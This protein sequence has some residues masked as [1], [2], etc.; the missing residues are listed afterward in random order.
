MKGFIYLKGPV[1][2]KVKLNLFQ[3]LVLLFVAIYLIPMV[4]L[5]TLSYQISNRTLKRQMAENALRSVNNMTKNLDDFFED[6]GKI[7]DDIYHNELIN[8]I[9]SGK[10]PADYDF[11]EINRRVYSLFAGKKYKT[12]VYILDKNG[13]PIYNSFPL[14]KKYLYKKENK[15]WGIFREVLNAPGIKVYYPESYMD[16]QGNTISLSIAR[17]VFNKNNECMGFIFLDVYNSHIRD[18]L[19]G[20]N[21]M[22]AQDIIIIDK[23]NYILYNSRVPTDEGSFL[24]APYM[25]DIKHGQGYF[26]KQFDKKPFLIAYST[27]QLTGLTIIGITS[28]K[29]FFENTA[30]ITKMTV[31]VVIGVFFI[32]I[33]TAIFFA[34]YIFKPI[35]QLVNAMKNVEA[36]DLSTRVCLHTWDEIQEVGESFNKMVIRIKELIETA[37]ERQKRLRMAEI[38]ALQAQINPH[39]I[40]NTLDTINWIARLYNV[41]DISNI[42]NE[43][44]KL[45]RSTINNEDDLTTVRDNI[46]IINSYLSIEKIRYGN[47]FDV[48][49]D[50]DENLYDYCIPKFLLQPLVEN[51]VIHGLEKKMG[52]GSLT[53]RGYR[54]DRDMIF[55]IADDGAGMDQKDIEEILN[56]HPGKTRHSI[57]IYNVNK[58]LKLYFGESYGLEIHSQKGE[59]TTIIIRVPLNWK[60]ET[61]LDKGCSC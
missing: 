53:I 22:V 48:I 2:L 41:Y 35:K 57:G 15:N 9:L 61:F 42:V 19:N 26:F 25:A 12:P 31:T 59:G 7:S 10:I 28:M 55:K 5:G 14:P 36:G 6:Y 3:K 20:L 56:S 18:I 4:F 29:T 30:S 43:F 58:R 45:L 46:A 50:V 49:I 37:V 60:G 34:N 47:K 54:D 1:R 44:G 8:G 51:A 27:S 32:C 38:K 23:N 11:E 16:Y 13:S 17:S 33:L 52:K 24:N 39:F 21:S 40:Y